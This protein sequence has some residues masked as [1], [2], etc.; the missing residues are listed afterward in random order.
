M[1]RTR[2]AKDLKKRKTRSD[3]KHKYVKRKGKLVPYIPKRKRGD[4]IK[5]WMWKEEPMSKDGFK[6]WHAKIRVKLRKVIYRPQLRV[7][8]DPGRI[9]SKKNIGELALEVIGY[10]GTWIMMGF[11]H[12]TNKYRVKPVKLCKITIIQTQKGLVANVKDTWR[13]SRYWFWGK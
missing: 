9:S 8:V 13:L 10:D 11:S 12:G 1:T 7:D 5:L 4:P 6:H 3:R 2:G